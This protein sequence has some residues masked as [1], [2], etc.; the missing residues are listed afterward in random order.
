MKTL[1][2]LFTLVTMT[3][4]YASDYETVMKQN[5]DKLYKSINIEEINQ[6]A[7][8]FK[9]IAN[10][11]KDKWL[12]KYYVAYA[13]TRTTHF[14]KDADSIDHQLDLAQA[15]LDMLLKTKSDE[16]E[17]YALQALIYSVR[18][19]SPMRG[20][21]YSSLSNEALAKAE[22]LNASNPRI[23]YCRA[24][25]VYHTP[26]MFGGGKTKA[27][28]LY[29]KAAELFVNVKNDNPLWPDWGAYHNQKMLDKCI[30]VE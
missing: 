15:E 13:Y 14:M 25:N 29:E 6:L 10:V 11:E 1:L 18:I 19:T 5:I 3:S 9:R 27:K 4:A 23:Y 20:Y 2:F 26:K 7:A 21:K 28:P 16:S 8:S 17:V 30:A 22:Q 24:N 12:P